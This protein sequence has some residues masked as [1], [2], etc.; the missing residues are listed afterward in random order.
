MANDEGQKSQFV[1]PGGPAENAERRLWV[2]ALALW[3][4]LGLLG[5]HRFYTRRIVSGAFFL[6]T[7]L[8]AFIAS[9]LFAIFVAG[10]GSFSI[11]SFANYLNA[12]TIYAGFIIIWWIVDFTMILLGYFTDRDGRSLVGGPMSNPATE[13]EIRDRRAALIIVV[14]ALL[15]AFIAGVSA[16]FVSSYRLNQLSNRMSATP[17]DFSLSTTNDAK[18]MEVEL[19]K[20]Q[21]QFD[22]GST[23]P[24]RTAPKPP[25]KNALA[26]KTDLF[27]R[28]VTDFLN[29]KATIIEVRTILM[30]PGKARSIDAIDLAKETYGEPSFRSDVTSS[31]GGE[32]VTW[33]YERGKPLKPVYFHFER[34]VPGEPW[35]IRD[36]EQG[37]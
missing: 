37:N 36:I 9:A 21:K 22:T 26:E 24:P 7:P 2:I 12:I 10:T 31:R 13:D 27:G 18:L 35:G 30:A 20:I 29:G 32:M 19:K 1:R 17:R 6:I 28:R 15:M 16:Y 3:F 11:Q 4:L 25:I 14:A 23:Q 33:C 34:R 5:A 8:V